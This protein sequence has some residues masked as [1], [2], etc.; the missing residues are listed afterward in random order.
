[1]I[2][3]FEQFKN[4]APETVEEGLFDAFKIRKQIMEVQK[5][6]VEE[7]EQLLENNPE[8]YRDG[9][10]VM[11]DVKSFAF[12]TYKKVVTSKDAL[13]FSQWWEDFE[14]SHAYLL[15]RTIFNI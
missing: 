2:K 4:D 7:Y 8:H 3:K 15:D 6:V 10:S 1:M 14:K 12:D 11:Q 5:Q 13:T 9:K